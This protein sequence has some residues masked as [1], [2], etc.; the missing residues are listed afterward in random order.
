MSRIF[1]AG[2]AAAVVLVAG[3][4][5]ADPASGLVPEQ[6]KAAP[7][8]SDTV[9]FTAEAPK[10]PA[11]AE[12]VRLLHTPFGA[13]RSSL[14]EPASWGLMIIGFGGM[15]AILRNNRRATARP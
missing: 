14:P 5:L 13:I 8:Y 3:P 4:A 10:D 6:G 9:G 12:P 2:C 7:S 1:A 15:G 11:E